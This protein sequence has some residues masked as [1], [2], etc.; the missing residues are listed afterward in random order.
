MVLLFLKGDRMARSPTGEPF[1]RSRPLK[2]SVYQAVRKATY[3]YR[4]IF[5]RTRVKHAP[6]YVY[7]VNNLVLTVQDVIALL[8]CI[9]LCKSDRSSRS[10]TGEPFERRQPQKYSVYQ[11]VRKATYRYRNI[12][13]RTHVKHAPLYVYNVNNLILTVQDIIDLLYYLTF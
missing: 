1:E 9:I 12:F 11:A 5:M 10:L 8:Y 2:Y 6:L 13:M 3:R 4:N 7:N